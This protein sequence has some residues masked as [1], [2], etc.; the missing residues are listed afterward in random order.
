MAVG[1]IAYMALS[2]MLATRVIAPASRLS[3]AQDTRIG[4]MLS[5]ALGS[6]A[7][8]KAFGAEARE[9]ARLDRVV[10]KWQR[11]TRRTWMR[12]TWSGTVAARVAVGRAHQGHRRCAVAVVAGASDARRDHLRADD[13]F[14]RARAIC[15]TSAMHVHHL[16]RSVNEMEE[17]VRLYDTQPF[18]VA[19]DRPRAPIAI[20][21]GE[22]R[23]DHVTFRYAGH[24]APLYERSR[25]AHRAGRAGRARRSFGL[26]QDDVRQTDPAAVRRRPQAAC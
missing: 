10:A 9:D 15:A 12:H 3:N 4:G 18:G 5:D 6:N 21:A 14:R 16:Q 8:V 19:D 7:V 11:R 25:R 26:G 1:A 17:L 22:V 13:V 2:V 24:D 20:G 23:F